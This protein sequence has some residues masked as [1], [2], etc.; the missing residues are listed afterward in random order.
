L[1]LVA[2]SERCHAVAVR[3]LGIGARRQEQVDDIERVAVD[4]PVQ[5]GRSVGRDR[6]HV[7]LL[8]QL[9]ADS[10]HIAR[11]GGIEQCRRTGRS[12]DCR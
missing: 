2:A 8:L 9:G 4:G 5:G 6:V 3:G 1:P 11:L 7:D 10:R 12:G